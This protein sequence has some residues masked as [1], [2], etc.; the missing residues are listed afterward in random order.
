MYEWRR[1]QLSSIP[2]HKGTLC[3]QDTS[4]SGPYSSA[5][6]DSKKIFIFLGNFSPW[7]S[8]A[9]KNKHDKYVACGEFAPDLWPKLA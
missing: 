2:L 6:P 5:K 4:T 9:G 1:A 3:E 8:G 7:R